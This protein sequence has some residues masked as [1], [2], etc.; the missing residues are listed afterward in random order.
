MYQQ[1]LWTFTQRF[2]DFG[3]I[4]PNYSHSLSTVRHNHPEVSYLQRPP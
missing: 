2:S 3:Y 1:I 4:H